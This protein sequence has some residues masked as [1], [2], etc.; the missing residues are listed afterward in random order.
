MPIELYMIY[1]VPIAYC[2]YVSKGVVVLSLKTHHN[3]IC[4]QDYVSNQSS[5]NGRLKYG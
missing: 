1:F 2:L 4:D 5:F 3:L